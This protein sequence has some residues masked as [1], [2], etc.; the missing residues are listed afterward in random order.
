M[1]TIV[2]IIII[3]I[4]VKYIMGTVGKYSRRYMYIGNN[5]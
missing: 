4:I 1:L 3:I 5:L 2:I